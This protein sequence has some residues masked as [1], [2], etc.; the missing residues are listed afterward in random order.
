MPPV[1]PLSKS[2]LAYYVLVKQ[3]PCQ[4]Q[5]GPALAIST[6]HAIPIGTLFAYSDENHSHLPGCWHGLCYSRARFLL[7]TSYPGI[8]PSN[9]R[10]NY[11]TI[12]WG[13]RILAYDSKINH[14]PGL[15][16][17]R[18]PRRVCHVANPGHASR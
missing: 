15:T 13:Y 7:Y 11:H 17:E 3:A 12:D 2:G 14:P 4:L 16:A 10:A 6:N 8:G 1:C 18:L 9:Y 5:S